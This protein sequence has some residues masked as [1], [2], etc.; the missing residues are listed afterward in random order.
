MLDVFTLGQQ[1]Y[2]VTGYA[3]SAEGAFGGTPL[4]QGL[5]SAGEA[6]EGVWESF[7]EPI[8][9]AAKSAWNAVSSKFTGAVSNTAGNVTGDFLVELVNC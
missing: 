2:T 1:M 8:V 7:K 5:Q 4:Q 3:A 9:D 6:V